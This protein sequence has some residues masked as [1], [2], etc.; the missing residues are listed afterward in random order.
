M[1][2]NNSTTLTRWCDFNQKAKS[3]YVVVAT[4]PRNSNDPAP[5]LPNALTTLYPDYLEIA[6]WSKSKKAWHLLSQPHFGL[7]V[8]VKPTLPKVGSWSPSGLPKTQSAIAGVKSPP[9]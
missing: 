3:E 4:L 1:V 7:S 8:R 2:C 5:P 9:I 6:V